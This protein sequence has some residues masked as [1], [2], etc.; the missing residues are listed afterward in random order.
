MFERFTQ[1]AR[2]AVVLA[3][4][5]ARMLRHRTIGTEHLLIG[6]AGTGTD[7]AAQALAAAGITAADLRRR[8]RGRSPDALDPAALAGLGID[9]DQVRRAAEQRF[10][11]GALETSPTAPIPKGHIPFGPGA[12][13]VLELALRTEMVVR[14]GSIGSGHVLVGVVDRRED[15]GAGLLVEAGVDLAELR[16][17]VIS[18]LGRDAA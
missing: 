6:L 3:Q 8:L 4:E 2:V 18:R 13:K 15:L 16:A 11:P 12:K 10:G 14:A 7:A 17:A 1:S 5:E 9:L